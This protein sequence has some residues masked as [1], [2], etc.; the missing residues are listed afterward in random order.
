MNKV[1][2]PLIG[3]SCSPNLSGCWGLHLQRF[4]EFFWRGEGGLEYSTTNLQVPIY[5]MQIVCMY[6]WL[7]VTLPNRALPLDYD[8]I[9]PFPNPSMPTLP[10]NPGYATEWT[11]VQCSN[12]MHQPSCLDSWQKVQS[13]SQPTLMT[14]MTLQL[15]TS[16]DSLS[17]PAQLNLS[18]S[19]V[20]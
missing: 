1:A 6:I 19:P 9:L 2:L 20:H 13:V 7:L 5:S 18:L 4:G 15:T 14:S 11:F 16:L 12:Q 10:P 3:T 17:S 8:G